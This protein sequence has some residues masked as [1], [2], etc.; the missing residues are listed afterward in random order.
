M[1]IDPKLAARIQKLHAMAVGAREVGSLAEADAFM[2]GV[3]KMLAA[4]NLDMSIVDVD[5]RNL[6][7]PL[8]QS[9]VWGAMHRHQGKPSKWTRILG[10][11]VAEAHYCAMLSSI[12]TSALFFYGRETNHVTAKRMYIYL[13]DTAERL[14]GVAYLD[15]AKRRRQEYGTEKGLWQWRLNWLEGF[16]TQVYVRYGV[17]RARVESNNAMALVHTSVVQ[18]AAAFADGDAC[19]ASSR[20]PVS[21]PLNT[22]ALRAGARAADSISLRPAALDDGDTTQRRALGSGA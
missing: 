15:E 18:E 21:A 6:T 9:S 17:L 4:H 5:L 19:E 7:D 20:E 13:R 8:G 12:N 11:A 10:A 1:K 14:C 22:S 16:A 3:E 2:E